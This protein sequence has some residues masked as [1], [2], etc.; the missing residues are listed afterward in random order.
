MAV[1]S[2]D[3]AAYYDMLYRNKDYGAEADYVAGLLRDDGVSGGRLLDVGCGTGRHLACMA[4]RGFS[5][6]GADRSPCSM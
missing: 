1:F 2:K 6:S 3:Y 4:E 5:V